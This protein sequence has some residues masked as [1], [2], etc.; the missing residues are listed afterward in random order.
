MDWFRNDRGDYAVLRAV[1][2]LMV[3][4]APVVL[5]ATVTQSFGDRT[6]RWEGSISALRL[7]PV[8]I[9]ATDGASIS[10]A[11]QGDV[12]ITD[13]GIGLWWLAEL[14]GLASTLAVSLIAWL[15]LRIVSAASTGRPFAKHAVRSLRLVAATL[16]VAGLAVPA[17][18]GIAD[19]AVLDRAYDG[20]VSGVSW[21][22]GPTIATVVAAL[23]VLTVAEAFEHGARLTE[24]VE[25]LV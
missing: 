13:P 8:S 19:A 18:R 11:S 14:P 20:G 9:P 23:L 4:V 6:L 1:L 24:D 25:G 21:D 5:A 10:Y 22:L 7:D 17:L 15:L 16:V 12:E 2:L 3:L